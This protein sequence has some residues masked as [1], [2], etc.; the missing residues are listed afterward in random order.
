MGVNC[1][2]IPPGRPK[3][4]GSYPAA[5]LEYARPM[6]SHAAAAQVVGQ[7]V[8]AIEAELDTLVDR[9]GE[10]IREEIPDFRRLPSDRLAIAVRGNVG[11]A[12]SALRELR[13]PT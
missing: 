6:V 1:A 5:V 9:I 10:R 2:S 4:A 12:L 8:A 3:P 11:R 13:P 7:L